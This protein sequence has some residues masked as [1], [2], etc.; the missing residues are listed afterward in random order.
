MLLLCGR[1][2]A[3]LYAMSLLRRS[4]TCAPAVC[5]RKGCHATS[6]RKLLPGACLKPGPAAAQVYK[7]MRRGVLPV[8]V[9]VVAGAVAKSEDAQL[10]F[11][12][13]VAYL[14]SLLCP[15]I[16]QFQVQ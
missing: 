13:E 4:L 16:V 15:N 6:V 5:Q 14:R 2:S 11:L 9:K 7:A 8:A 3:R 12:R 1:G 10:E